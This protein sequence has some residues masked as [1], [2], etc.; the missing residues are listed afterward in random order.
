M[1][2]ELI[3][4]EGMCC[5]PHPTGVGLGGHG[6]VD[7]FGELACCTSVGVMDIIS[8][9]R[10]VVVIVETTSGTALSLGYRSG[11]WWIEA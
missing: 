11:C 9:T 2:G 3:S 6:D 5:I 1:W 4:R 8:M 10:T 7:R